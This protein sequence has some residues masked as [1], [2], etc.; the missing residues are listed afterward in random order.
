MEI[1]K[2]C[3]SP[4][5]A[6]RSLG[7]LLAGAL[8]AGPAAAASNVVDI[9]FVYT[10]GAAE[11]GGNM[12]TR[13]NQYIAQSNQAYRA[14]DVDIEL[15]MVH[16]VQSNNNTYKYTGNAALNQI[17][18]NDTA[19]HRLRDDYGADF[20]GLL[21]LAPGGL[22][23]V[24]W[25]GQSSGGRISN[26]S[27][28]MAYTSSAIDCGYLTYTHELGHNMGMMHSRRQGDTSGGHHV[29]GMGYGVDRSFATLM[30][31]AHLFN[32]NYVYRF[33]NPRQSCNGSPCGSAST[34]DAARSLG[35]MASQYPDYR[36]TQVDPGPG[37]PGPGDPGPEP[38]EELPVPP[39]GNNVVAN[40][41]FEG[42]LSSWAAVYGAD[43]SLS[44]VRRRGGK[45]SAH[46]TDR[47]NY[48]GGMAQ[49][50]TGKI[51]TGQ[52]YDFSA[53]MRLGRD[54]SDTARVVLEVD[55]GSRYVDLGRFGVT[56]GWT[57]IK[58]KFTSDIASGSKVRLVVY[59][60]GKGMDFFLD[61]V[62]ISPSGGGSGSDNIIRNGDFESGTAASWA[63]GFG[64]KIGLSND[65]HR[66][67]RSLLLSQRTQWFDSVGQELETLEARGRYRASAQVKLEGGSD[68]VS[69]WLL[70]RDDSGWYWQRLAWANGVKDAWVPLVA[71]DFTFDPIGKVRSVALHVMG[72]KSGI[73]LK[74]DDVELEPLD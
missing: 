23:G 53:W 54:A 1:T 45:R 35:L 55:G 74:I 6:R 69:L 7:L 10:P 21:N 29:Y 18:Y 15:R 57:E 67:T 52:E 12:E 63:T 73:S 25:L 22:C 71:K 28:D 24:G 9:M 34:G 37:D 59:G 32:T 70:I 20:V 65:G 49:D 40:P 44:E 51:R 56:G 17:T 33:S 39:Q 26:T 8:C 46:V 5:S 72:P 61:S 41:S 42:S 38:D 11:Y 62:D 64:G 16:S 19:I 36:P 14:S 3:P 13:L 68:T 30:A 43:V 66:S 31:Y 58:G 47:A 2:F 50:L 48:A 60:P 27:K 4:G